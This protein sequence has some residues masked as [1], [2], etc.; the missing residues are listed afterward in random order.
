VITGQVKDQDSIPHAW[1][2]AAAAPTPGDRSRSL[3][4]VAGKADVQAAST[5]V[6]EGEQHC[7]WEG[8]GHH[9]DSR[10]APGR[11]P[12]SD[13]NN[14]MAPSSPWSRTYTGCRSGSAAHQKVRASGLEQAS[15]D[16]EVEQVGRRR[17]RH[18]H[19]A[20]SSSEPQNSFTASRGGALVLGEA[21]RLPA[22]LLCFPKI[23][24]SASRLSRWPS[25]RP[26]ARSITG[27][28]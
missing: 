22:S 26:V 17:N 7:S 6:Q 2:R 4:G 14:S 16:V 24:Q 25:V 28:G 9:P 27:V 15:R 21:R 18:K 3:R 12:R 19:E 20:A 5:E 23:G 11:F 1:C 10:P 13:G 8:P